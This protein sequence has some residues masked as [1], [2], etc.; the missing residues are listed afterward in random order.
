MSYIGLKKLKESKETEERTLG[1][2]PVMAIEYEDG[3]TESMS[4]TMFDEVVSEKSCDL[5]ELRD[6]RV[7]PVVASVL[8]IFREWGLKASELPYF[9]ALL[10][11]SL[12]F[13]KTE[14]E[15]ELWSKVIPN[16]QSLDDINMVDIDRVLK[17]KKEQPMPSTYLNDLK[18]SDTQ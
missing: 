2:I 1:G 12:D 10:N 3:T 4:K 18:D 15:K 14:A 13:N 6:K 8:L 16:I 9:S 17:S 11:Q 5:T 7:R